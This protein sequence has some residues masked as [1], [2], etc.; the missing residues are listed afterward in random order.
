M[1]QQSQD[2]VNITKEIVNTAK[3]SARQQGLF[4]NTAK[5]LS[6]EQAIKDTKTSVHTA[7]G[8]L[9]TGDTLSK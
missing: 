2:A 9:N 8:G 4:V 7:Q 3:H 6:T 5:K 1:H